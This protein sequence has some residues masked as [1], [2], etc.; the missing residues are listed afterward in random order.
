MVLSIK[1]EIQCVYSKIIHYTHVFLINNSS[2]IKK[3]E[4][5]CHKQQCGVFFSQVHVEFKID[6]SFITYHKNCL[7]CSFIQA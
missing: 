2:E 1:N 5:Q 4:H 3:N 7:P 6:I